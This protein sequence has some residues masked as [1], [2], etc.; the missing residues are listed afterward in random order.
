MT[1]EEF[2]KAVE[3][4]F[5]KR[6]EEDRIQMR[7]STFLQVSGKLARALEEGIDV[8]IKVVQTKDAR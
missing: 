2:K 8:V 7:P 4:R 1:E 3:K 6:M 5:S